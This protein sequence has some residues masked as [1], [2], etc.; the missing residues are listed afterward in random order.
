MVLVVNILK[1]NGIGNLPSYLNIPSS[2]ISINGVLNT[3]SVN[4]VTSTIT[5]NSVVNLSVSISGYHTY[6]KTINNVYSTNKTIEILLVAINSNIN[7]STYNLPCP[8]FFY[9]TR[10]CGLQVDVYNASSFSGDNEYYIN[11]TTVIKGSDAVINLCDSGTFQI[12]QKSVTYKYMPTCPKTIQ[13]A[14]YWASDLI[15]GNTVSDILVDES[16]Y[17]AQNLTTNLII[18]EHRPSFTLDLTG[19]E[20]QLDGYC[21]F[22]K[23]ET[24]NIKANIT[25]N[26]VGATVNNHSLTWLIESPTKEEILNETKSLNLEDY[27]RNLNLSELGEYNITLTLLD[28]D[29]NISYIINEK[30]NTC[31]FITLETKSCGEFIVI[32]KSNT[33]SVNLNI[34]DITETTPVI[35]DVLSPQESLNISFSNISLFIMTAQ[36]LKG[37]EVI[38]EQYIINNYCKIENCLGN[39]ISD[40]LCKDLDRCSPCPDETELNQMLLINYSYFMKL[41]KEYSFNN[42]YN[43]LSQSKLNELTSLKQIMDKLVLFC[44]R[45]GCINSSFSFTKST[46]TPANISNNVL[47]CKSCGN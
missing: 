28:I 16:V 19:P 7:S 38:T 40:L 29:C 25:L 26:K 43:G 45:K 23:D 37:T 21:C 42:F 41:N 18:F 30:I 10:P 12:K 20:N 34:I 46:I 33:V 22:T 47:G 3:S 5:D 9:F 36:Y 4:T 35:T 14:R 24:V 44:E 31:N 1:D 32:N 39:Y 2:G 17:L 6:T 13:W 8:R 15:N 27:N 11:N